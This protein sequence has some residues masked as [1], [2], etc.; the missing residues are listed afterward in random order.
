MFLFIVVWRKW[1]VNNDMVTQD[2]H[3]GMPTKMTSLRNRENVV[4]AFWC[5]M[6]ILYSTTFGRYIPEL[7]WV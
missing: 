6:L 2:V 3:S 1:Q 5:N 7:V 4:M